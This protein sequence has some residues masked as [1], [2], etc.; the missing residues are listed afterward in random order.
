M[1]HDA[2][3]YYIVAYTIAAGFVAI[4]FLTIAV[5]FFQTFMLERFGIHVPANWRKVLFVKLLLEIVAAG[6]VVFYGGPRAVPDSPPTFVSRPAG[7]MSAS[8]YAKYET[9]LQLFARDPNASLRLFS[10]LIT[11]DPDNYILLGNRAT[12]N[13]AMH[14]H[15]E[16]L[17]DAE[18]ARNAYNKISRQQAR[19][20]KLHGL[21]L[22]NT[23]MTAYTKDGRPRDATDLYAAHRDTVSDVADTLGRL[24]FTAAIAALED[25][26]WRT[27]YELFVK[28]HAIAVAQENHDLQV[29]ARINAGT[30]ALWLGAP[31]IER[32]LDGSAEALEL[33]SVLPTFSQTEKA[34]MGA[35]VHNINGLLKDRHRKAHPAS[36]FT[37]QD[38]ESEYDRGLALVRPIAMSSEDGKRAYADLVGNRADVHTERQRFAEAREDYISAMD[39]FMGF[40]DQAGF[41]RQAHGLAQLYLNAALSADGQDR[42]REAE[43]AY[44]FIKAAEALG[45]KKPSAQK[46]EDQDLLAKISPML[47]VA[48]RTAAQN[49]MQQLISETTKID[50]GRIKANLP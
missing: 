44:A 33:L 27:A 32:A 22:A 20:E 6:L 24:Y 31:D 42:A 41:S 3:L 11:E 23:L 29:R 14:R 4:T 37:I 28:Q 16:G 48:Q 36:V 17:T 19:R 13:L 10:D 7:D 5:I 1:S 30:A 18:A 50:I 38:V 40:G 2:T 15:K 9:A 39:I 26:A 49:R 47:S 8:T 35:Q 12:I 21:I 46:Q 45:A 34:T 43:R 25:Q